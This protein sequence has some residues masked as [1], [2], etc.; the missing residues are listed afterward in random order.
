MILCRAQVERGTD[1]GIMKILFTGVGRTVTGVSI[2][3]V[4]VEG[5]TVTAVTTLIVAQ[6]VIN[7]PTISYGRGKDGCW[8]YDQ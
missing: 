7:N 1:T 2:I 4:A 6:D 8:N 5:G 3:I